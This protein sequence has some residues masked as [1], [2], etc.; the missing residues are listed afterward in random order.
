MWQKLIQE[1]AR[2]SMTCERATYAQNFQMIKWQQAV[3]SLQ[4]DGWETQPT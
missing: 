1:A 4:L 3:Y 2:S